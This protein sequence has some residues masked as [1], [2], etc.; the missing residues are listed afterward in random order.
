[1]SL[2]AI[3]QFTLAIGGVLSYRN[4]ATYV[5]STN[6]CA[7]HILQINGGNAAVLMQMF[8]KIFRIS[9]SNAV[10]GNFDACAQA[11][12]VID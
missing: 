6:F 10:C 9:T 8:I 11:V 1:M 12:I 7:P 5:N 2:H 4:M 3:V